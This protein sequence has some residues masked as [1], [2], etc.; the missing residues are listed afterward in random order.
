MLIYLDHAWDRRR[1]QGRESATD[2]Y[3]AMVE[4]AVER[5]RPKMMTVTAIIGGLL[6]ILWGHGPGASVMKRIAAPMVGG[7]V[8]SAILTLVVIPA[9]WSL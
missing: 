8:S 9:V 7:M 6:P 1:E 3:E 4:G 5:V 2:L